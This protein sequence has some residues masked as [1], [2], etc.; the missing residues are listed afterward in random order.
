MDHLL[1]RE[2]PP[3]RTGP[4]GRHSGQ[5][6]EVSAKR[7]LP[8]RRKS[9]SDNPRRSGLVSLTSTFTPSLLGELRVSYT[10]FGYSDSWDREG[11]DISTLGFPQ[12]L[13]RDV[14]YKTFPTISVSQYTVGTGLSV[15]GGSSAEVGDLGR[16]GKELHA[17]GHVS[18]PISRNLSAQS[19]QVQDGRRSAIT[20]LVDVQYDCARRPVLLRSHLHAR[21]RIRRSEAPP[22]AAASR[23]FFSGFRSPAISASVPPSGSMAN[24]TAS[25]SRTTYRSRASSLR[26]SAS[27]T[28]TRLRGLRSG[29]VSGTSISTGTEP[30]TGAKGTY[31]R[32]QNGQYIYDPQKNNW[33]PRVGIAYQCD[34][35]DSSSCC[36]R[37]LLR[38]E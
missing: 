1:D 11:F 9:L 34:A 17:A 12:S 28:N 38:R 5:L 8:S 16:R 13:A 10:R 35:E 4:V 24:T 18:A 29:A 14:Q 37:N 3:L 26:T 2:A 27:V 20:A 31:V 33:S 32:L 22:A 30:V 15:T 21:S 19:A 7:T 23:A 36:E 6:R 25:T